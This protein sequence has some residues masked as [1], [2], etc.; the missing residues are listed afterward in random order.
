MFMAKAFNDDTIMAMGETVEEVWQELQ[1]GFELID[2]HFD[3][4]EWFRIE[5]IKVKR[6][7]KFVIE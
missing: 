7:L 2:D 1:F 5:P 3:D 4:L 6:E